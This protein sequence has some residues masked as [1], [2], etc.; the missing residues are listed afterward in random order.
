MKI[1]MIVLIVLGVCSEA[2]AGRRCYRS[3][4]QTY[5]SSHNWSNGC[6]SCHPRPQAKAYDWRADMTR[7]AGRRLDNQSFE[8]SLAQLFGVKPQAFGGGYS[9]VQGEYTQNYAGATQY[10]VSNYTNDPLVDLNAVIGGQRMLSEQLTAAAHSS[11]TDTSDIASATYALESDRQAKIAA[12]AAIQS[13]ARGN[14]AQLS[15]TTFRY[16]ASSQPVGHVEAK[17]APQSQ[18]SGYSQAFVEAVNAN[19]TACHTGQGGGVAKLDLSKE[20][21]QNQ[22]VAMAD[23]VDA[24]RMPQ[25]PDGS[26]AEKLPLNIRSLFSAAAWPQR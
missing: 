11:A 6:Y 19:C 24:G 21:T 22:L 7:I 14:P 13:V 25:K 12:F 23:A 4:Y 9:Q 2:S 16:Q 18:H 15:N 26:E 20:L 3:Y 5:A 8:A 10:G 17:Q 1:A